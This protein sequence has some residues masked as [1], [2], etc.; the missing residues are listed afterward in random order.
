MIIKQIHEKHLLAKNCFLLFFNGQL[1]SKHPALFPRYMEWY[2]NFPGTPRNTA[3]SFVI[4]SK[5]Y[6]G[7]GDT[8]FRR[9][10][11]ILCRIFGH[12]I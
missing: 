4:G 9:M 11:S 1:F 10:G 12:G 5:V 6:V 2:I 3:S 8:A 7:I